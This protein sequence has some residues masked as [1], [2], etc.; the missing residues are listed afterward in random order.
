LRSNEQPDLVA[1]ALVVLG[2]CAAATNLM[3]LRERAWDSGNV[4]V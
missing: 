2:V 4:M 3:S 1:I